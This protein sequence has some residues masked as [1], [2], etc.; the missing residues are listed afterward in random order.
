MADGRTARFWDAYLRET[1]QAVRAARTTG[2]FI[3]TR[4]LSDHGSARLLAYRAA[5]TLE[6]RGLT[7]RPAN[8]G[9][10]LLEG[11]DVPPVS[12]S[13]R[14]VTLPTSERTRQLADLMLTGEGGHLSLAEEAGVVHRALGVDV[15]LAD[16]GGGKKGM[17]GCGPLP[18]GRVQI[19]VANTRTEFDMVRVAAD[20]SVAVA[21]EGKSADGLPSCRQLA[22][23]HHYL[24]HR[25]PDAEHHSVLVQ[26]LG[27]GDY[28]LSCY[29]F[30][31]DDLSAPMLTRHERVRLDGIA[32]P[33]RL[34]RTP[35]VA[36]EPLSCWVPQANTIGTI[37]A[38]IFGGPTEKRG[39]DYRWAAAATLGLATAGRKLTPAGQAARDAHGKERDRIVAELVRSCEFVQVAQTHGRDGLKRQLRRQKVAYRGEVQA[40]CE[41]TVARRAGGIMAWCRWLDAHD[42]TQQ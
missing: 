38:T 28:L 2:H 1:P 16:P 36:D 19:D 9:Y 35:F 42:G 13:A 15:D 25:Y 7:L 24:R 33:I 18:H 5:P 27:K 40:M 29:E 30:H 39:V 6:A 21:V 14:V 12:P 11:T 26:V 23:Q 37:L 17:G 8:G 32:G 34:R 31:D 41:S 22:M 4:R 10:M 20:G 3:P